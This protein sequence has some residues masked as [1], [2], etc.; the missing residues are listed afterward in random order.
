[1]KHKGLLRFSGAAR[2]ISES[3]GTQ[4]FP[5]AA[6]GLGGFEWVLSRKDE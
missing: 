1:V 5:S 2:P 3:Q 6:F 4:A